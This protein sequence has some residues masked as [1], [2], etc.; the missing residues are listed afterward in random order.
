M[1]A[2]AVRASQ[3]GGRQMDFGRMIEVSIGLALMYLVLSLFCTI[4]NEYIASLFKFR[5]AGLRNGLRA[6]SSGRPFLVALLSHPLLAAASSGRGA[7]KTLAD[8]LTKAEAEV[9]VRTEAL[10]KA[11]EN[12]SP[13]DVI[14]HLEEVLAQAR[15][16]V[17]ALEA[18]ERNGNASVA[19]RP[20]YLSGQTFASALL[21]MINPTLQPT[22]AETYQA[23]LRGIDTI[24]DE[25]V[26]ASLRAIV[27]NASNDLK[28][29]RDAVARWFDTEMEHLQ[30]AYKRKMQFWAFA[31]A[32]V[33]AAAAN[34]DTIHVARVLW[35]DRDGLAGR[36]ADEAGQ[37]IVKQAD[38]A[39]KTVKSLVEFDQM[40]A[41]KRRELDAA[42]VA[43]KE[44]KG[45]LAETKRVDSA[46]E[47][48]KTAEN[49]R[50]AAALSAA[51]DAAVVREVLAPLPIGWSNGLA[52]PSVSQALGWIL[53]ALALSLGSSFWFDLLS[54]F[55]NIRGAGPKP[56]LTPAQP[57]QPNP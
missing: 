8:A 46:A 9:T 25:R 28:A 35:T 4:I 53:T 7:K 48:L 31:I 26:R 52:I 43:L 47:A 17:S 29:A 6:L 15:R 19:G 23:V 51:K 42:Q 55:I 1:P 40:V 3:G 50:N 39:A 38:T 57:G 44:G 14:A 34:A 5:A 32:F 10:A 16:V 2:N 18:A 20:S 49:A 33:V 27:N 24:P 45:D 11:K 54:K 30:G 41:A 12:A 36:I 22:D 37:L 13:R 56:Q 21:D